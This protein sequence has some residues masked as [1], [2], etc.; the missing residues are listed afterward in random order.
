[1]ADATRTVGF[2]FL[3]TGVGLLVGEVFLKIDVLLVLGVGSI[4]L[5]IYSIA[6]STELYVKSDVILA[7]C[8]AGLE[9][10]DRVLGELGITGKAVYLPKAYAGE[11]R[12]FVPAGTGPTAVPDLRGDPTFLTGASSQLGLV[13]S[14]PGHRLCSLLEE[15]LGMSLD[16]LEP[17]AVANTIPPLITQGLGLARSMEIDEESLSFRARSPAC[18]DLCASGLRAC[19]QVGCMICSSI[20]EALS[21]S[22]DAALRLESLDYDKASDTVTVRLARLEESA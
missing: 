16:G 4:F 19:Q 14:P 17:A 6:M 10:L 11:P 18:S 1:M 13:I 5:G 9:N 3:A 8:A 12:V 2:L 21:R 22:L 7:A 20:C 15:E